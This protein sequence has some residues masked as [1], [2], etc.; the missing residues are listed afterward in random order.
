[1]PEGQNN[2][3]GE[4]L[5]V[6]LWEVASGQEIARLAGH[7][8]PIRT[9]AFSPDGKALASGS[10]D[11]TCLVWDVA[12][13]VAGRSKPTAA[14][15][16]PP[17]DPLS[18]KRLSKARLESAWAALASTDPP[19]A[20]RAIS[21]LRAASGQAIPLL[22]ERVR[23]MAP[24]AD[25]KQLACWI[26]DLDDKSFAMREKAQRAIERLDEPAIP[27]LRRALADQPPPEV[28]RR[29]QDILAAVEPKLWGTRSPKQLRQIRAVQVLE[30]IGTSEAQ[31]VLHSLAQGVA[32]VGL[33]REAQAAL[34][35]LARRPSSKP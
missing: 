10:D 21:V 9:L 1:V 11:L 20:Y 29:L 15:P 12:S 22:K 6:T 4:D 25:L 7:Q 33:T 17:A 3:Y 31:Q 14:D 19:K 8:A 24:V 34:E 2:N 27:A 16:L 5:S 28:K 30:Y 18:P 35:R 23:P 26:A 32:E 13:A